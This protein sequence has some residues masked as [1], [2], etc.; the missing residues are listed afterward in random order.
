[1][2]LQHKVTVPS[3]SQ[4]LWDFVTDVPRVAQCMPWVSSVQRMDDGTY[5]ATVQIR[6]GPISLNMEGNLTVEDLQPDELRGSIR[7]EAADRRAAGVVHVRMDMR[8]EPTDDNSTD[9]VVQTDATIAGKLGEFGQPILR[10]KAD[11]MMKEFGGNL[12]RKAQESQ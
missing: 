5:R 4:W 10:R 11:S 2:K 7:A 9:L 12:A 1:M 8:L 3:S 6:V